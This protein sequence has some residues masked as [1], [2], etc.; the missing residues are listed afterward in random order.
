MMRGNGRVHREKI[1][2]EQGEQRPQET[3]KAVHPTGKQG[4]SEGEEWGEV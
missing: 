1:A 3:G 4:G 2:F